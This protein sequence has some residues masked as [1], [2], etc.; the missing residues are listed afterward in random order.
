MVRAQAAHGVPARA[1]SACGVSLLMRRCVPYRAGP[2][3]NF[4][5]GKLEQDTAGGELFRFFA[6][7]TRFRRSHP[8]L[9][10]EAFLKPSDVTWH[11]DRWDD[12]EGRCLAWTLHGGAESL[13]CAFNAH[14]FALTEIPLPKPPPGCHWARVADTSLAPP[15]D[16]DAANDKPLGGSYT[17]APYSAVLLKAVRSAGT[18]KL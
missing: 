10:R 18:S 17:V 9:G 2:L 4:Q 3:N 12:P 7:A 11:E 14:H 8:L 16:F 6:A 1:C 13:Y 15:R 5:W